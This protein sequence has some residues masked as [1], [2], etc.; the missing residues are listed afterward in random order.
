MSTDAWTNMGP[1]GY[2]FLSLFAA[3]VGTLT[4]PVRMLAL[5]FLPTELLDDISI[6]I[7]SGIGS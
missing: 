6:F 2:Y 7:L 5:I 1:L 4:L 3:I